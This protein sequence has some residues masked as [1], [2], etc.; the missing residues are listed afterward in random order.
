MEWF[1]PGRKKQGVDGGK[2]E[3]EINS[4]V[5]DHRGEGYWQN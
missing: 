2:E 4:T 3:I 1:I 5:N